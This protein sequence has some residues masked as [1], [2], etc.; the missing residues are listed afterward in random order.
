MATDTVVFE[1]LADW[2]VRPQIVRSSA[3]SSLVRS[4][5]YRSAEH[6]SEVERATVFTLWQPTRADATACASELRRCRF[7]RS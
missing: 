1:W 4:A 2:E 3:D 6:Q 5:G 7:P